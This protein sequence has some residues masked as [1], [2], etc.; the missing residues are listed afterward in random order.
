MTKFTPGAPLIFS[1]PEAVDVTQNSP[2]TAA[3]TPVLFVLSEVTAP[4]TT[5]SATVAGFVHLVPAVVASLKLV[6]FPFA[7]LTVPEVDDAVPVVLPLPPVLP[8]QPDTLILAVPAAE[9]V[10]LVLVQV[11][12][13]GFAAPAGPAVAAIPANGTKAAEPAITPS[14]IR[15]FRTNYLL[16]LSVGAGENSNAVIAR[17]MPPKFVYP[18]F[19]RSPIFLFET[20]MAATA[21]RCD[22]GRHTV[23]I[24]R[25]PRDEVLD[26]ARQN[27]RR[28]C[29][30]A[31]AFGVSAETDESR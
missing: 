5:S 17:P 23:K 21:K 13:F 10:P 8:V 22:R 2:E 30:R 31:D 14:I 25:A 28:F 9:T 15:F 1:F 6:D 16:D 26:D 4:L 18:L 24:M 27:D 19:L 29:R 3:P 11:I 12:P 20:P 7:H